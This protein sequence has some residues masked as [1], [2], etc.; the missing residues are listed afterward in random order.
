MGIQGP[1]CAH[2]PW[3][4]ILVLEMGFSIPIGRLCLSERGACPYRLVHIVQVDFRL[5]Y[6][7]NKASTIK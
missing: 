3:G 5:Q 2:K 6:Y 4:V 7:Y 1:L